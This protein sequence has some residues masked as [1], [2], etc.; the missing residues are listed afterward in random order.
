VPEIHASQRARVSIGA[1]SVCTRALCIYL[2]LSPSPTLGVAAPS[3]HSLGPVQV[4][5]SSKGTGRWE[6]LV[7]VWD[8]DRTSEEDEGRLR[9]GTFQLMR[10]ELGGPAPVGTREGGPRV[11]KQGF[12]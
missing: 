11:W 5:F 6:Q 10:R 9:R 2:H 12:F 1:V 3:D 8:E 4:E 7:T